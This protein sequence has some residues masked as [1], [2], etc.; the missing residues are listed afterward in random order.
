MYMAK[1]VRKQIYIDPEQEKLLKWSAK[2][3]GLSEAE[4][5]RKALDSGIATIPA[6][7]PRG[8]TWKAEA[9]FIKKWMKKGTVSGGRTWTR[10]DL[11][12]R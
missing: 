11:H 4:I 12:G 1:K 5:I 7:F 10:D 9:A 2:R 3:T 8:E 6:F